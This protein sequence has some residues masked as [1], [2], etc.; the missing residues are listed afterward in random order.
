MNLLTSKR[1]TFPLLIT[2]TVISNT[3]IF[4]SDSTSESLCVSSSVC[5]NLT[6]KIISEDLHPNWECQQQLMEIHTNIWTSELTESQRGGE[7]RRRPSSSSLTGQ[8]EREGSRS[9]IWQQTDSVKRRWCLLVCFY[10]T[11]RIQSVRER[12]TVRHVR[13]DRDEDPN[14][15]FFQT[16]DC[17]SASIS[18]RKPILIPVCPQKSLQTEQNSIYER[19]VGDHG[20]HYELD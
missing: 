13:Y 8:R 15:W 9:R 2:L 3:I 14:N 20:N 4:Q 12:Q 1:I 19:N 7:V 18:A 11:F 17:L 16:F 6:L 10:F 5:V